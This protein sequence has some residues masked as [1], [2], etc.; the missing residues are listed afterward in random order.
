MGLASAEAPRESLERKVVL[1]QE[2]SPRKTIVTVGPSESIEM[3][4]LTMLLVSS[5]IEVLERSL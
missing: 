5:L 4:W 3:M 1:P 2:G